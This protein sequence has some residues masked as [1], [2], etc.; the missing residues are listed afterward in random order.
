[1]HQA[2]L[3]LSAFQYF[4]ISVPDNIISM[5]TTKQATSKW[6]RCNGPTPFL[7]PLPSC[8]SNCDC[9]LFD[10]HDTPE[11]WRG[12]RVRSP[13]ESSDSDGSSDS[14]DSPC[15]VAS[16]DSSSIVQKYSFSRNLIPT[17]REAIDAPSKAESNALGLEF[18]PEADVLETRVI[19][20]S[21]PQAE[22]LRA[23]RRHQGDRSCDRPSQEDHAQQGH[24]VFRPDDPAN[25][26]LASGCPQDTCLQAD[27]SDPSDL[28]NLQEPGRSPGQIFQQLVEFGMAPRDRLEENALARDPGQGAA[29]E[30]DTLIGCAVGPQSY[31]CELLR[32][33]RMRPISLSEDKEDGEHLLYGGPNLGGWLTGVSDGVSKIT[34]LSRLDDVALP[35][36]FTNVP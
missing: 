33:P 6:L 11:Y 3:T 25:E 26:T 21:T 30:A 20:T 24:L 7:S 31:D 13:V 29:T 22:T 19:A 9:D 2:N 34:R 14:T 12:Y 32:A 15:S 5:C 23:P 17:D 28:E 18:T 16:A 10:V 36:P 8:Q 35:V 27:A 1:M 4:S